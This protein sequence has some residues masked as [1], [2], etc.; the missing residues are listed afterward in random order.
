M[1]L[2]NTRS[3]C[4]KLVDFQSFVYTTD[5][6]VIGVTETWLNDSFSDKEILPYD[7]Q[8]FRK[9]RS[10]RGGGV[11]IAVRNSIV[12]GFINSPTDL[13][14]VTIDL[15]VLKCALCVVYFPPDISSDSLSKII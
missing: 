4:N 1:S 7:Y 12:T 10:S 9:D 5:P 15:I 13:E 11:L 3:L 2:L 6:D 8:I 14:I